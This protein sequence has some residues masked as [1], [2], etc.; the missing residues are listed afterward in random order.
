MNCVLS[1]LLLS[2]H[3]LGHYLCDLPFQILPHFCLRRRLE[4]ILLTHWFFPWP[5]RPYSWLSCCERPAFYCK[6]LEVTR[7][8][9]HVWLNLEARKGYTQVPNTYR[10]LKSHSGEQELKLELCSLKKARGCKMPSCSWKG[11]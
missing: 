4:A 8:F 7:I 10:K 5:F 1:T 9:L 3:F 11:G 6:H 2:L